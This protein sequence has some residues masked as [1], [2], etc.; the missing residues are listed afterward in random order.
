MNDSLAHSFTERLSDFLLLISFLC[1]KLTFPVNLTVCL[2]CTAQTYSVHLWIIFGQWIISFINQCFS[3]WWLGCKC[4]HLGFRMQLDAK[5]AGG[6]WPWAKLDVSKISPD[7]TFPLSISFRITFFLLSVE[8]LMLYLHVFINLPCGNMF[9][10][11]CL[12]SGITHIIMPQT[13]IQ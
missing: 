12:S 2:K 6:R 1:W 7:H 10:H 3:C 4:L 13:R 9:F 11:N 8:H 5:L